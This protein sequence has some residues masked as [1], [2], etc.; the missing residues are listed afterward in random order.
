MS[1]YRRGHVKVPRENTSMTFLQIMT[2]PSAQRDQKLLLYK[3]NKHN[4]I[5]YMVADC[6]STSNSFE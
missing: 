3:H 4:Y 1:E 5:K 6:V 2:W